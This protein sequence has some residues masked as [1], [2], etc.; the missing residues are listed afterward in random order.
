MRIAASAFW[1]QKAGNQPTEYEDAFASMFYKDDA[2]ALL[3][4]RCAV[5]DGATETS[6]SG[7]WAYVLALAYAEQRL[8]HIDAASIA[9]L[10]AEWQQQLANFR[11][12]KPL[13]WYAEE[14]LS[15]GAYA[16]LLGLHLAVD[17]T[18]QATSV[19][20]SNLFQV[21]DETIIAATPYTRADQFNNHP[22]LLSTDMPSNAAV[23]PQH[24]AG[25]WQ[26]GDYFFLM[27]DALAQTF[28]KQ[29]LV[30]RF[31]RLRKQRRFESLVEKLRADQWC[32]NDDVTLIRIRL[33][34]QE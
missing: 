32:K 9:P 2:D 31:K 5:A 19:G 1:L 34:S 18:W 15:H 29:D 17:G 10:T 24:A 25:T 7:L 28:L 11:Q 8:T 14:K 27:T 4:F 12:E 23:D 13:P 6:F 30:R 21:R 3:A 33:I 20:D 22:T 26:V 16:T